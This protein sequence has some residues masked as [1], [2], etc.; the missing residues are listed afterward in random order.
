VQ[1]HVFPPNMP[2]DIP[3]LVFASDPDG[4]RR[5][6]QGTRTGTG[7]SGTGSVGM[8]WI[9]GDV[10]AGKIVELEMTGGSRFLLPRA[11]PERFCR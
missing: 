8:K 6:A 10:T 2:P 5:L 11:T 4:G 1:S 3:L 9:V 7:W